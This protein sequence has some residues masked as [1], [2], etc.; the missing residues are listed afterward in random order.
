MA[1]IEHLVAINAHASTFL[2]GHHGAG[3]PGGVTSARRLAALR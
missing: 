3:R 2:Q 1:D